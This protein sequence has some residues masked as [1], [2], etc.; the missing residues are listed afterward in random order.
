MSATD[1]PTKAPSKS[2]RREEA[3]LEAL[4]LREEQARAARRKRTVALAAAGAVLLAFVVLVVVI[5]SQG[6]DDAVPA[7]EQVQPTF[8]ADGGGGLVLDADGVVT[9]PEDA[10]PEWPVGAFDDAVVVTVYSD[11]IC[12]WCAVFEEVATPVLDEMRLAGD[13]VIDHR[14]V[15][16]LDEYS[17]GTRYSTRAAQAIYTVAQEAPGSVTAFI[18][19]IFAA[20]PA[21]G[22]AGLS[23]EQIQDVAREA[24]V[25]DA[26]V[27]AI[28][29]GRFAWWVGEVTEAAR[30]AH[31]GRLG[32]PSVWLDGEQLDPS[33]DWRVEETLRGAIEDARG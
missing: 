30:D 20:Q 31:D 18:E 10:G 14:F 3:R 5:L 16:N 25:P 21:E 8:A 12:P 19:A 11:P 2:Q 28:A 17:S 6:D 9:P 15:G 33:V 26:A 29:E 22:T 23:D 1:R 27:E 24:G 32:T 4:R 7:A 13:V